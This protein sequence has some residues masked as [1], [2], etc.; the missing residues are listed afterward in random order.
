MLKKYTDKNGRVDLVVS[1]GERTAGTAYVMAK[2]TR[3][4]VRFNGDDME[5]DGL[6]LRVVVRCRHCPGRGGRRGG[7]GNT[8]C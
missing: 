4:K 5:I 1:S 8:P 2:N 7:V 3:N 6:K